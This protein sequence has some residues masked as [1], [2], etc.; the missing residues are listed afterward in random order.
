[1]GPLKAGATL[2]IG[3]ADEHIGAV[4]GHGARNIMGIS[5]VRIAGS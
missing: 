5:Q 3:V 1:M 4:V 2:M